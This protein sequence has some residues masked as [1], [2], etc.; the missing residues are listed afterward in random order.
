MCDL[1]D[2]QDAAPVAFDVSTLVDEVVVALSNARIY[3]P[4]HPRVTGAADAVETGLAAWFQAEPE[5]E[6]CEVGFADGFLFHRRRPLVGV[7]L[8]ATR[9]IEPLSALGSGGLAFQ[10]GTSAADVL[11]LVALLAPRTLRPRDVR[12]A[13]AALAQVGVTRVKLLPPY[14]HEGLGLGGGPRQA[15]AREARALETA[16]VEALEA[17]PRAVY[18]GTVE[19]LQDA[20]VGAARGEALALD[21]ARG[22]VERLQKRMLED[23]PA[24]LGLAR[25]ERY[26]E[27]TF[28]HS[29]RVCMLALQF[30]WALTQDE[31][32][33]RRLGLA[34]LMHDIGKSRVPFEILHAKRRLD[35]AE[36]EQIGRHTELGAEILLE[37][38]DPDLL[39]VAVAF[40]H[41][42]DPGGAGGYPRTADG[43][44]LGMATRMI[45]IC[46]VYEALTAVRPYKERMSPL[47][48]YRIMMGMQG[49][50]D[51]GLLRRFIQVNGVY[52]VG[53][54]VRL[55]SGE[56]AVVQRQTQDVLRPIVRVSA[57][58]IAGV[59][60][61]GTEERD[62]STM[63]TDE[64]WRVDE[65]V[66]EQTPDVHA[67]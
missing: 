23:A 18:Q 2:P 59:R 1:H 52:P 31:E 45:R 62:L 37:M 66:L 24:M 47:R 5:A 12:E 28:G 44:R 17:T 58:P 21:P 10:R 55:D 22:V 46:D 3:R 19:L 54:H 26:D 11:G 36:K 67:A 4:D 48:A 34:A 32:S 63:R 61:R 38:P 64:G 15:E 51:L 56:S 60:R 35:A 25:Y 13:N 7:S 42:R 33:V 29:I 27:F 8:S 50:F 53:S 16:L 40:G 41:H 57:A 9:L 30:G 39:S 20:A 49:H 65:I 14:R 6:R 43:G